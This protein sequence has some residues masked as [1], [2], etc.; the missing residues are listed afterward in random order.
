MYRFLRYFL[1]AFAFVL[2]LQ[3]ISEAVSEFRLTL[4]KSVVRR[5]RVNCF[6]FRLFQFTLLAKTCLCFVTLVIVIFIIFSTHI[7]HARGIGLILN[8]TAAMIINDF[9]NIA[10][11][12]YVTHWDRSKFAQ[13]LEV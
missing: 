2:F 5:D 4:L 8:Y 11:K 9:D 6:F 10:A 1:L 13:F 3:D 7:G 12:L